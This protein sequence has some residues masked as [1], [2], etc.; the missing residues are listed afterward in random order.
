MRWGVTQEAQNDHM[1]STVCLKE[2]KN[3]QRLSVGPDF[4]VRSIQHYAVGALIHECYRGSSHDTYLY[5]K[6]EQQSM[7]HHCKYPL[8]TLDLYLGSRSHKILLSTLYIM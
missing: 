6:L 5:R 8:F 2:I 1:T 3:C 4:V 7:V